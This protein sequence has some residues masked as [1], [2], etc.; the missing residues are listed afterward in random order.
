MRIGID[1]HHLNGKPQGSRTYL[2]NLVRELVRLAPEQ[3]FYLYS[4]DPEETRRLVDGPCLRQR[5]VFPKSARVRLP[6]V[7]PALQ[8]RDRLSVFHSQYISPPLSG[9]AEV[10]S[11][12][13]ILFETHPE[14]FKGAFSKTSIWLIRRSARRARFVLTVSEFCRREILDRYGLPAER[15]VV[16]PDAVDA[17]LF[18]PL[19][20]TF[21]VRA[22]YKLDRP[23]ILSVGRLEPRKNLERLI[24]AFDLARQRIDRG[25]QL[26]VVGKDDFH[27]E[28]IHGEAARLPEGSVRFLGPVPDEDLPA[29]YNI[30]RLLAFPS[31]VEG[32]GMPILEAMAC[33]T[34]V[35]ASNRGA[36]AEVGGD[37]ALWV[38]PEDEESIASGIEQVLTGE[39]LAVKLKHA[40]LERA[41]RFRWEDTAARTLEVY[42]KCIAAP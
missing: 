36:L 7:V 27:F 32:F 25:L 2:L 38:D 41:S 9:I 11:I 28:S 18:R 37:A 21:D 24:R 15:V 12:H 14:L 33:G 40:G 30:A 8:A 42:R 6:I 39:A 17:A 35:V 34:P 3:S 10:V 19:E 29:L 26:V 31:L 23:F 5:R 22:R 20:D 1:G 16:T 13:D 4:F